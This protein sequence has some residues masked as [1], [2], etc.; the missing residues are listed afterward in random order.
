MS[1]VKVGLIG[2][3]KTLKRIYKI[4]IYKTSMKLHSSR[5]LSHLPWFCALH[6]M[7]WN[8]PLAG[9]RQL[10]FFCSLPTSC[11]LPTFPLAGQNEKQE[12]P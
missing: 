3:G 5:T 4:I 1:C 12:T 8:I 6:H 11:A 2:K 9:L 7:V 10:S